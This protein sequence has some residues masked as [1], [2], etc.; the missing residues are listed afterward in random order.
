MHLGGMV[1]SLR[2]FLGPKSCANK[3]LVVIIPNELPIGLQR[4]VCPS[5]IRVD[6]LQ[7]HSRG[8]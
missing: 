4:S 2:G 6:V 8:H 3:V 5:Y 7:D 1:G